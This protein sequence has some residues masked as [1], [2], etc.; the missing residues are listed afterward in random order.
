MQVSRLCKY[1]WLRMRRLQGSPASIAGGI[2]VG[3]LVGLTPTLPF[4]TPLILVGTIVTRTSFPAGVLSSW[5]VCNPVTMPVIYYLSYLTGTH[6]Y[7]F[8]IT[9][10]QLQILTAAFRNKMDL[11][12]AISSLSYLGW[13]T[14][15]TLL[16]GSLVFALP[17]AILS[18]WPALK[19]SHHLKQLKRNKNK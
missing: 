16:T 14:M 5:V 1:Y 18:Y 8:D 15:I 17:L 4:Q 2:G 10:E 6:I 9:G 19:L 7:G 11:Q 12:E 3:V 13:E